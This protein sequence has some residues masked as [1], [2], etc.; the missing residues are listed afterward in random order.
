M[1][2]CWGQAVSVCGFGNLFR[3]SLGGDSLDIWLELSS[4]LYGWTKQLKTD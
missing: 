4:E 1:G 2:D 3:Q